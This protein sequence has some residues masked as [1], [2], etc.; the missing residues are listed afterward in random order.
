MKKYTEDQLWRFVWR[1]D[2]DEK[3]KIAEQWL[4]EHVYPVDVG[5]WDDLRIALSRQYRSMH[6]QIW[7]DG[8]YHWF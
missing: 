1:A 5:L 8:S 7:K 4:D 6:G 3:I 2:T